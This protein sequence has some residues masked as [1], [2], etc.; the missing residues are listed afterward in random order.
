MPALNVK[1]CC[2][3][4]HMSQIALLHMLKSLGISH[5][6]FSKSPAI[7]SVLRNHCC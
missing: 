7:A 2:S 1:V 3:A 6:F 4:L 5:G